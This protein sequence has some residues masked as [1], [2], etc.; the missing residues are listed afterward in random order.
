MRMPRKIDRSLKDSKVTRVFFPLYLY[1]RALQVWESGE[2]FDFK[3][4][5]WNPVGLFMFVL[6]AVSLFI[7][8]GFHN[9]KRYGEHNGLFLS[10][11][12]KENKRNFLVPTRK[13]LFWESE[14]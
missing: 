1:S 2:S 6:T 8:G 5:T 3:W 4:N 14:L 12:W 9:F 10:E 7:L 13:G 11:Y